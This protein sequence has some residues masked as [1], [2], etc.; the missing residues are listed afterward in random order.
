VLVFVRGQ[1]RF[2]STWS[3]ELASVTMTTTALRLGAEVGPTLVEWGSGASGGS[4]RLA[5]W[6]ASGVDVVEVTPISGEVQVAATLTRRRQRIDPVISAG[7]EALTLLGSTWTFRLGILLDVLP[8]QVNYEVAAEGQRL[9]LFRALDARP[10]ASV[11]V[12]VVIP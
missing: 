2:A 11:G 5:L 6:L 8:N 9:V 12:G 4:E 3:S 7:I 1:H 10:G